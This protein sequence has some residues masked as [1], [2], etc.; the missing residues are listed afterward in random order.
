MS[1]GGL[2]FVMLFLILML[3]LIQAGLFLYYVLMPLNTTRKNIDAL[4]EKAKTTMGE[5]VTDICNFQLASP[6]MPGTNLFDGKTDFPILC[7]SE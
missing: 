4:T 2:N 5:T 7:E 6:L 1:W 3:M